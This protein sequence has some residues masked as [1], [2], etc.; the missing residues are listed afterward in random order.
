ME[1]FCLVGFNKVNI[2]PVFDQ[3]VFDELAVL[4]VF[5]HELQ[6]E[7]LRIVVFDVLQTA[8]HLRVDLFEEFQRDGIVCYGHEHS[9]IQIA[10]V[11]HSLLE[12][13]PQ[14]LANE[15]GLLADSTSLPANHQ[16]AY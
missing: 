4:I 2:A 11:G 3:L 9:D 14:D 16:L 8:V 7:R 15:E 10:T 13:Y 12:R 5:H 1:V 6:E